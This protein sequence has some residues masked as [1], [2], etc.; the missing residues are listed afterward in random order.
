VGRA[1][2]AATHSKKTSVEFAFVSAMWSARESRSGRL[3]TMM[4]NSGDVSS[5]ARIAPPPGRR[6]V[7]EESL[8]PLDLC[9][10]L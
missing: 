8:Q 9:E 7:G 5:V 1:P 2:L 4:T 3:C 10:R 6:R